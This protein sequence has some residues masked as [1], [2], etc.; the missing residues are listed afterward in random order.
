M[1]VTG[2][3]VV[4]KARILLVDPSGVR[5]SDSELL[6]WVN[7][8]QREIVTLRGDAYIVAP[9]SISLTAGTKQTLPAGGVVL[10]DIIRNMGSDG[11]TPGP[12]IR[13]IERKVLDEQNVSWHTA[14]T[15]QVVQ[16][17]VF[18][19]S[20]PRTFYVYPPV[21]TP[22]QVEAMYVSVPADLNV[23]SATLGIDDIYQNAVLDYVLWRAYS[24]STEF[25][26]D[27]ERAKAY[28]ESFENTLSGKNKA[29]TINESKAADD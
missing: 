7:D 2:A 15:S 6:G 27:A 26:A 9:T 1:S 28:R 4:A 12:A 21:Q 10:V 18:E 5:W 8:G 20:A 13:K 3:Q 25:A 17:Y 16:H 22:C 11:A 14:A 29:D 24:K 23:L 19:T